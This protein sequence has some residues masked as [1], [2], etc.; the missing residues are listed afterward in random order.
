MN[1]V[2]RHEKIKHHPTRHNT[3]Q[4][5]HLR[6]RSEAR[7]GRHLEDDGGARG[8]DRD[9]G[10]TSDLTRPGICEWTRISDS[11]SGGALPVLNM[12]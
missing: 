1:N 5:K 2:E 7:T 12:R 11:G 8:G 4:K 3:V 9:G 6:A 10:A